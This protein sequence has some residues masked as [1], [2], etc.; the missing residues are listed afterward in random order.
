MIKTAQKNYV[1]DG[2][3]GFKPP[4]PSHCCKLVTILVTTLIARPN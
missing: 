1:E 2:G 4:T 3:C